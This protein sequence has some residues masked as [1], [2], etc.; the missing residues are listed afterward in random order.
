MFLPICESQ[1]LNKKKTLDKDINTIF[2]SIN[3]S[4][5]EK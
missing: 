5:R 3:K 4:R 1:N 2:T